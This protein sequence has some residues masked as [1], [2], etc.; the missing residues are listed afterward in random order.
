MVCRFQSQHPMGHLRQSPQAFKPT[1]HSRCKAALAA[2]RREEKAILRAMR[3]V[4]TVRPPKLL[5]RAIGR[6]RLQVLGAG[7][8]REWV[9]TSLGGAGGW[10]RRQQGIM[11]TPSGD[12]SRLQAA[13]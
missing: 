5:D 12:V 7:T 11:L 3:L 2:Q 6:P 1:R 8:G 13:F 9:S 10:G 4:G